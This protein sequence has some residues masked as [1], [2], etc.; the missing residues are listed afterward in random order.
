MSA[1]KPM[2]DTRK[3]RVSRRLEHRR[4]SVLRVDMGMGLL[5][6]VAALLLAPGLALVAVVA[7]LVLAVC[8]ISLAVGRW[9]SQRR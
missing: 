2:S 9:R 6:A 3:L 7:L 1:P 5:A 8:F 4:R